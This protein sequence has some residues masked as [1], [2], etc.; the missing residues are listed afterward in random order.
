MRIFPQMKEDLRSI[1]FTIKETSKNVNQYPPTI[2]NAVISN[3]DYGT[4]DYC[5]FTDNH[6]SKYGGAVYIS[7]EDGIVKNKCY[8][9][10]N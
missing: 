6:D 4:V 5:N 10:S 7:N 2:L 3:I 9:F 8:S 1:C